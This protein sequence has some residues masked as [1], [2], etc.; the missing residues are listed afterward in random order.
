MGGIGLPELLIVLVIIMII[1]GAGKIPEIGGAFGRTIRNFKSS[2]KDA[3]S[4]DVPLDEASP[5]GEVP[6]SE[7]EE[8]KPLSEN[9]AAG[10]PES[11][12]QGDSKENEKTVSESESK[13]QAAPKD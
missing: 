13:K 2:M 4:Q 8:K 12:S 5:K 6:A 9:E 11:P 3:E 1:F 7:E 10:S